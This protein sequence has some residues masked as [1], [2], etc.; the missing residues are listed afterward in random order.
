MEHV[1]GGE[2]FDFIAEQG[3]L[4]EQSAVCLFRQLVEAILYCHRMQI[5][6]RDLKPE[7]ILLDR[8]NGLIKLI[9]FG[10]AAYQPNNQLLRTPCGSPHYAA[11]E[12]LNNLPYDGSTAD[13]WS[14]GVVLFV[15]LTGDP[16]F[17]Y[18]NDIPES[19]R[20]T[21]L[22]GQICSAKYTIPEFLSREAKDLIRRIFVVDPKRR[23]TIRDLWLHPFMH[24]YDKDFGYE[25]RPNLEDWIGPT[26][27]LENWMPLSPLTIDSE[28]FRNLLTLWHDANE[29]ILAEKLCNSMYVL[30]T[31]K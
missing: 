7:N 6:H 22:Y 29:D 31:I 12:L 10:M 14:L 3:L 25:A 8:E 18:R 30:V 19:H 13:V 23:I 27:V 9:D 24:K 17:N 2:L 1:Q 15:M 26:P 4:D 16:P 11:P 21:M 5:S 28:I 20:L